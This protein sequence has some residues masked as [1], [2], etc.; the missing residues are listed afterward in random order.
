MGRASRTRRDEPQ[1]ERLAMDLELDAIGEQITRRPSSAG[2]TQVLIVARSKRERE[3]LSASLRTRAWSVE[4]V[5]GIRA[6]SERLSWA[7]VDL[8]IVE[9]QRA[10]DAAQAL[11]R[12]AARLEDAPAVVVVSHKPSVDLAVGAMRDGADDFIDGTLAGEGLIERLESAIARGE[13]RRERD[14][15]RDRLRKMCAKLNDIR[16]EMFDQIGTMCDDLVTAYGELSEQIDVLDVLHE[17]QSLVRRELDVEA[18]LRTVLEYLL[19]KGGPTN[20]A[21]FLPDSYGD[22]SLG[23]YVNYDCPRDTGEAMLDHLADVMPDAFCDET[24]IAL[25]RSDAELEAMLGDDAHWL[26]GQGVLVMSC[27]AGD[28]CLAVVTLFR[29]RRNPFEAKFLST[30]EVIRDAFGEQLQR[31]I[32]IHHRHQPEGEMGYGDGM[33]EGEF[34]EPGDF[35][36][37]A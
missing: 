14:G 12:D 23:A 16:R 15:E 36:L 26:S 4:A 35:G 8:L 33:D 30:L 32:R 22:F 9:A 1:A 18:L 19:A 31:V 27:M 7:S 24:R 21:I 6:A 11:V 20:A 2:K 5:Q 28:E 34:D 37:A 10:G 29:D 13:A 3:R 25:M 17:F